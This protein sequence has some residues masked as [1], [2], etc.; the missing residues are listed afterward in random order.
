MD[1]SDLKDRIC[2]AFTGSPEQLQEILDLVENDDA[3]FPFNEF[4]H[5][6]C[7]L[8][9]SGGLT[10]E[11]YLDL[12][13]EYIHANPN[14][15][16]FEVSAPR[17]FGE[18]FAQSHLMGMCPRLLKPNK[19]LDPNFTGEYDL[20]LDEIKI[21]VKASRVV[22][23]ES[24]APLYRK[25][26]SKNTTRPFVMN[27]Q[28]LKPDCCDVFIWVAVYRDQ[29]QHWILASREVAEH[30]SYSPGQHRGNH[31]NE[32][33]LHITHENIDHFRQFELKDQRLEEAIR[34]AM[35]RRP[36]NK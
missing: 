30:P 14:L 4:E 10:Y 24:D 1:L 28:Q 2:E 15:W 16:I 34:N 32:G 13:T 36:T 21:E 6:I 19:K 29:I 11:Q 33:Q 12:R 25:A 20:L 8:I 22:E 23:K 17:K 18:K 27:F 9:N 7:T 26:L 35:K 5:L 31:G 3:I